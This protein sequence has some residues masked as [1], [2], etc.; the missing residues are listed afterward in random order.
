MSHKKVILIAFLIATNNTHAQNDTYLDW[1]LAAGSWVVGISLSSYMLSVIMRGLYKLE[2]SLFPQYAFEFVSKKNLTDTFDSIVGNNKAKEELQAVINYF[3]NTNTYK[4]AGVKPPQGV[5]LYGEPGNGKTM[6]A[7]AT[8]NA[9]NC[10]FIAVSGPDL[11]LQKYVG[12]GKEKIISLFKMAR[13]NAPCIIFIDELDSVGAQRQTHESGLM[14]ESINQLLTEMD[15]FKQNTNIVIIGA[16]NTAYSLDK[17]LVR[18]G[19]FDLKIEVKPP[20]KE[21]RIELLKKSLDKIKINK[22][23]SDEDYQKIGDL[24][25]GFSNADISTIGNEAGKYAIHKEASKI[26]LEIIK[27]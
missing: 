19:R 25:E 6:L 16:T 14:R 1:A 11:G 2:E 18:S 13:N 9:S 10:N 24:T 3:K 26:N 12:E 17:A 23:I 15:G 27:N 22:D 21:N 20:T 8:A 7:R 4:E 5:L